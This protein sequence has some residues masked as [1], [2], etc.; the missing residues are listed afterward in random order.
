[1]PA[2]FE[3]RPCRGNMVGRA[4]AFGLQK[5]EAVFKIPAVPFLK[6]LKFL[7][8]LAGRVNEHAHFRS[9]TGRQRRCETA[10][11]VRKTARGKLGRPGSG[12]TQFLSVAL[13]KRVRERVEI[14]A[15]RKRKRGDDLRRR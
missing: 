2:V 1:M 11:A 4:L 8:A 9:F 5:H 12:Q 14:Y 13:F 6:R 10:L 7:K 3:P 15:S